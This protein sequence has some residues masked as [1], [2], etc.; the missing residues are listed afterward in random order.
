[1]TQNTPTYEVKCRTCRA[2]FKVALFDSHEKNLFVVD[3]K[4]W[5]CDA[6]KKAYFNR[7]TTE[8]T[9]RQ[10]DKGFPA[11]TGPEKMVSWAVK[12]RGEMLQKVDYLQKSLKFESD[13]EKEISSKA[14]E[15]FFDEWRQF[16]DAKW[17]IDRRTM[18]V[19]D[20]SQRIKDLS[21]AIKEA[22]TPDGSVSGPQV[23]D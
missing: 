11:L 8:L 14:F 21:A 16:T 22:R 7:Q 10:Q 2:L 3:K 15:M 1:M 12:I 9:G 23:S 4:D 18:N 20:I 6:C 17:W 19:R 5:Y 13:A